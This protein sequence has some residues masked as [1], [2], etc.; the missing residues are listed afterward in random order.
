ME[1]QLK[2]SCEDFAQKVGISVEE[3]ENW[4]KNPEEHTEEFAFCVSTMFSDIYSYTIEYIKNYEP[5]YAA[6][7]TFD[8][9]YPKANVRKKIKNAFEK[10]ELQKT[11]SHKHLNN[12][13]GTL[14]KDVLAR[15]VKP[16]LAIVG[17][18]DAGKTSLINSFLGEK[19]LP[20]AWTPET[21]ILVYI[22]HIE[23]KPAFIKDNVWIFKK[24]VDG[25]DW[26]E[27]K[28]YNESY[29]KRCHCFILTTGSDCDL[30]YITSNNI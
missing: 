23:D 4:Q 27:S 2:I 29:C 15:L 14:K 20:Q 5:M 22:K 16:K 19:F 24:G 9:S 25:A 13:L 6:P 10:W 1:N 26:E 30:E 21:S 28:L 11:D 7:L 12:K 3:V 17:A 18:S 8:F